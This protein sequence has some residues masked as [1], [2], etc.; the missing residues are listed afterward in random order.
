MKKSIIAMAL[1]AALTGCAEKKAAEAS[2]AAGVEFSVDRLFTHDGCTVYRFSD[3]GYLRYFTRC[4]G[5]SSSSA[6]WNVT[7]SCGKG[8][9]R[10]LNR[11]I[12]TAYALKD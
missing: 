6:Q 11:D 10:T 7:Q 1:L 12:P 5:A 9:T 4:D 2:S 3:A 8:C